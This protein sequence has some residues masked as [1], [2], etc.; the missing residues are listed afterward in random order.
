MTVAYCLR[1]TG[2]FSIFE[3]LIGAAFS[4]LLGIDVRCHHAAMPCTKNSDTPVTSATTVE[5]IGA[6][7]H[8]DLPH[9]AALPQ[10]S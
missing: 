2:A 1:W 8:M 5:R 6:F 9:H 4:A 3:N 7:A 10:F